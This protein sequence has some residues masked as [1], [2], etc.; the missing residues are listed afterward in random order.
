MGYAHPPLDIPSLAYSREGTVTGFASELES[1]KEAGHKT[2]RL[3]LD[4]QTGEGQTLGWPTMLWAQIKMVVAQ[5]EGHQPLFMMLSE[6]TGGG[7][8][9]CSGI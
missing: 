3:I 4:Q 5:S 6:L 9:G 2:T 7:Q 1:Q 8:S